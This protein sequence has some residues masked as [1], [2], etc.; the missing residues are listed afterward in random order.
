MTYFFF[1]YDFKFISNK[2]KI[3]Y[4]IFSNEENQKDCDYVRDYNPY[5]IKFDNFILGEKTFV[6]EYENVCNYLQLPVNLDTALELY[7]DWY[8]ERKFAEY[9]R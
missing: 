5:E 4:P 9:I 6:T 7:R 2:K 3:L 1:I 8:V